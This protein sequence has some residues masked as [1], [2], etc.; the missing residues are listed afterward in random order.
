MLPDNEDFPMFKSNDRSTCFL[1]TFRVLIENGGDPAASNAK[2]DTALHMHTGATQHFQYLLQQEQY[3]ADCA[4][5]NCY[6][7]TVAERHAR[8]YWVEGPAKAKLALEHEIDQRR[9][10]CKVDKPLQFPRSSRNLLLH[11]TAGHLR[12][13]FT[14]DAGNFE[15]ALQLIQM[16]VRED[17]DIHNVLNE[18]LPH[19]KTPLAQITNMDTEI[20]INQDG[21]YG[22][23]E[24]MNQVLDR[25]LKALEEADVNLP[26]YV[27][28]ERRIIQTQGIGRQWELYDLDDS[29]EHRVEWEFRDRADHQSRPISVHH[30]FRPVLEE[31]E[32]TELIEA[33]K[34]PGAWVEEFR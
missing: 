23:N 16:L 3:V 17:V 18:G 13:Y 25:W 26:Q 11:E 33:D 20:E 9:N 2:G 4:Q 19:S 31:Q 10:L 14:T 7:D 24:I 6:G 34:V 21:V 12:H 29:W 5:K 30:R 15:S 27:G 28:E 8:W 22:E 1:D 32:K